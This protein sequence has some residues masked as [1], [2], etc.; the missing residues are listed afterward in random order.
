MGAGMSYIQHLPGYV[1]HLVAAKAYGVQLNFLVWER[2]RRLARI[3]H[4]QQVLE[5]RRA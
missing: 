1:F 2:R 4:L 5:A 3:E